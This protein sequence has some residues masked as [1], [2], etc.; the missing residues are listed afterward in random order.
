MT[1]TWLDFCIRLDGPKEKAGYPGVPTRTL[2]EIEGEV[3]H[4]TEGPLSAALGELNK[5]ERQAS[6]H[7]T[8]PKAGPPLQ[9]YPLEAIT[10]HA[11]LPGDRRTETSLIGNLTLIGVEHVDWPDDVLND[12]QLYW[13]AELTRTFRR[14]CPRIAARP[15]ALRVNLWEHNWLSATSCPSGLIPWAKKL[16]ALQ[17]A[18]APPPP[19]SPSTP[20]PPTPPVEE[21]DMPLTPAEIINI[22]NAVDAKVSARFDALLKMLRGGGLPGIFVKGTP[23]A[24]YFVQ[25]EGGILVRH[26]C[27]N[28]ASYTALGADGFIQLSDAQIEAIPLGPPMPDLKV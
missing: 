5:L 6:W 8:V 9:H 25:Y 16:A 21:D 17:P 28:T 10:W 13:S 4:S 1:S 20:V 14:L 24:I 26:H 2:T 27:E 3:D 15:P 19:P 22:A 12:N 23:A 7:F 18:P 11:G